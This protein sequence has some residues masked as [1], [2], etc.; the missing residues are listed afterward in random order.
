[1]EPITSGFRLLCIF[2]VFLEN[3]MTES[4][5]DIPSFLSSYRAVKD[6]LRNWIPQQSIEGNRDQLGNQYFQ[7]SIQSLNINLN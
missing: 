1:M 4:P 6:A 5:G 2:D 3:G 7:F